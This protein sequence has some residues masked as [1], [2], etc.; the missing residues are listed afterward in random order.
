MD[1]GMTILN[2][3]TK[4]KQNYATWILIVLFLI[5]KSDSEYFFEDINNDVQR[6][7]DTSNYEQNDKRPLPMGMNKKVIGMFKDELGRKIMKEFCALKAKT[8]AY[9]MDDDIKKKRSKGIKKCIMKPRRMFENY[10]DS[11]LTIK[12]Y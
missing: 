5:Q 2:Q 6:C 9:L 7:F 8:Y 1:F 12:P 3:S 4:T 10:K 11:F